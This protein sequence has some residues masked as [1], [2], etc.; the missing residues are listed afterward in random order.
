MS[1]LSLCA[2]TKKI[3]VAKATSANTTV[4][5]E[6]WEGLRFTFMPSVTYRPSHVL[7]V[8][9]LKNMIKVYKI[10]DIMCTL[11]IV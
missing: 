5:Q 11:M 1:V 4:L 7:N 2:H 3:I 8:Y 10:M 9:I 6:D